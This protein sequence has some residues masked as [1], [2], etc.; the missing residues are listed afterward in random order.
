MNEYNEGDTLVLIPRLIG[1]QTSTIR[2]VLV[3]D[4]TTETREWTI[5]PEGVRYAYDFNID[6]WV[7]DSVEK[8]APKVV[9]PDGTQAVVR[10]EGGDER[11]RHWLAW[12]AF[13]GSWDLVDARGDAHKDVSDPVA[14]VR[15][16]GD[17]VSRA[18]ILEPRAITAKAVIASLIKNADEQIIK[19]D[20]FSTLLIDTPELTRVEAEFGVTS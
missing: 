15:S 5:R 10:L 20:L 11:D 14:Y 8:A 17:P 9:L 18:I 2:G 12:R 7:I 3:K 16:Q 6:D 4:R 19:T 13:N 1:S